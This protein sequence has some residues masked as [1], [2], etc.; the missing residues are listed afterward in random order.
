L[1]EAQR[2][3]DEEKKVSTSND[4]SDIMQKFEEDRCDLYI[5]LVG[6][7][8]H[9]GELQHHTIMAG[10]HAGKLNYKQMWRH[11]HSSYEFLWHRQYCK[12]NFVNHRLYKAT[13]MIIS[14]K[15]ARHKLLA[16]IMQYGKKSADASDVNTVY[17]REIDMV[18]R[19]F[20]GVRFKTPLSIFD[21]FSCD[22]TSRC[23]TLSILHHTYWSMLESWRF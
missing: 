11:K 10:P 19:V 23:L 18:E 20:A 7:F 5:L 6:K 2:K 22:S 12:T 15:W 4:L 13:R 8:E 9:C 14:R 1:I 21:K 3:E 16:K 17:L